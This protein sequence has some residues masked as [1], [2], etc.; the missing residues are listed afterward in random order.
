MQLAGSAQG[1]ACQQVP[2]T[3]PHSMGYPLSHLKGMYHGHASAVTLGEYLLIFRLSENVR[4]VQRILEL[5]DFGDID[6]C[7]I[8]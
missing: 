8:T 5:S 2:T 3:L 6:E 4:K 7:V 1:T